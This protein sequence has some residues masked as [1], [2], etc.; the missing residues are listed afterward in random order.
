MHCRSCRARLTYADNYCR[1]CGAAVE[2]VDVQV[3]HAAPGGPVSALREAALPAVTQGAAL[4]A[5]GTLLRLA[6]KYLVGPQLS[7]RG[8]RPFAR[9]DAARVEGD[10]AVIEELVYYRRVRTR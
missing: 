7:G 1:K 2:I 4:I 10:G 8:V 6:L 5:V 3:V 9:R